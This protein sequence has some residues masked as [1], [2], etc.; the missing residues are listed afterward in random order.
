MIIFNKTKAPII[1]EKNG[2]NITF[3][4]NDTIDK[5][6]MLKTYLVAQFNPIT[7]QKP[8][9]NLLYFNNQKILILDASG[10]YPESVKPDVVLVTKSP[11]IN[12]ERLLIDLKPKMVVA[13]ASN[14][15]SFL[16]QWKAS[17]KK[18]KIPFHATSEKG[19]YQLQ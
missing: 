2:D 4:S 13:D 8:L 6:R 15:K 9:G 16:E 12:F 10:V 5:N 7:S 17:C 3:I 11:K 14:Y 18:E 1:G 19:F